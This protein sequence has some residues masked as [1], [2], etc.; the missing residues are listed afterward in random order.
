MIKIPSII[1]IRNNILV[2]IKNK[3]YN[4]EGSISMLERSVW[5]IVATAFAG[6]VRIGFEYARYQYNQIFTSTA[7]INSLKL[8]GEQ[9][10]IYQKQGDATILEVK[11]TG[12]VGISVPQNTSLI[13]GD[14][15][16][17]TEKN[18]FL[19]ADGVASVEAVST[20]HG[21]FT[22]LSVGIE[23]TLISPIASVDT[24]AIVTNIVVKGEN[25]E[26][27]ED[28]RS[29]ISTFERAKPQGG[30]IPD[31]V[32]RALEVASITKAFVVRPSINNRIVTVYPLVS[33]NDRIPNDAK[34][35]EVK[36]HLENPSWSPPC[37]I[38]VEKVKVIKVN[39]DV[40]AIMPNN[41]S[42]KVLIENS[43]KDLVRSIYPLQY[44]YEVGN[45]TISTA[46]LQSAAL[47]S[48]AKAIELGINLDN[49]GSIPYSLKLGE[50]LD[51]GKITWS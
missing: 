8:K 17:I 13:Y 27:I 36:N 40:Y 31:F 25:T 30:A 14:F 35:E 6:A 33:G 48:N 19:D 42:I 28:L 7:D 45:D 51:I 32:N 20:I 23:L 10:G 18:I 9:Y 21:E 15:I 47:L 3:L 49:G 5:V 44:P 26:N 12:S 1:E 24:F 37:D 43:C 50:I 38:V 34:I 22:A 29:R 4:K 46:N 39:I 11:F 16:Y 2:D 41:E